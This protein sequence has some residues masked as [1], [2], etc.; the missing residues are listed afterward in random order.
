M[1]MLIVLYLMPLLAG[2]VAFVLRSNAQRLAVLLM[3]ALVHFLLVT[4]CW[5]KVPTPTSSG[6][7][8]LDALGLLFLSLVSVLFLCAALYAA[9]Y[10]RQ[11][12]HGSNRVFIGCLLAFLSAMT[13]V[14]LSH[15]LAL[16]WVAIE[17]TTLASAPLIYF[18]HSQRSLEA[19]WKYLLICSIGIALALLGTFFVAIA[20]T[21]SAGMEPSLLLETLLANAAGFNL[22]WLKGAL[23][24]LLIGYG[25]KMGL[26]P[27]HT[28]LPDAHSEAPSPVSALLSG[29]LLNCAFLGILRVFQIC[30]AAGLKPFAQELLVLFG[31]LSLLTAAAF[32]LRQSDYK[33]MLAY[34]SVEHMGILALGVG[35]G[36]AATYGAMLHAV[37]HSLTK[38]LLF[39]AAGNILLSYKTKSAASVRGVLHRLPMTGWLFLGGFLAITGSPPFGPFMSEFAIFN[40]AVAQGQIVIAAVYL[41]LLA[42]VFLGMGSVVLPMVQG[43]SEEAVPLPLALPSSWILNGVPLLLMAGVLILGL[44]VPSGLQNVL[45]GAASL[46]RSAP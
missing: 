29:A 32:L 21:G 24:F 17:A 18:H 27:L 37:N 26:A 11:E 22:P 16:L 28:W 9:G 3:T 45:T 7:L 38:A 34:S 35:L 8:A 41:S 10:L 43:G 25:T 4:R 2:G 42:I 44:Y 31:L 39:F 15:H 30:A 20:G 40:A 12:D 33:R 1:T 14:T 23:I 6:W 36:G 13:L 5:L 19:T 46:L